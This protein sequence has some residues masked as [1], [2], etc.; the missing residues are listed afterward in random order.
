MT[1]RQRRMSRQAGLTLIEVLIT[2]SIIAVMASAV[3]L[4]GSAGRDRS[5]EAEAHRLALKLRAAADDALL[6]R[7]TYRFVWADDSYRFEAPDENGVY[8]P[9]SADPLGGVN[10][11]SAGMHLESDFP[12]N[13]ITIGPDGLGDDGRFLLAVGASGWVVEF[14]GLKASVSPK[15]R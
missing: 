7:R 5:A 1:D 8:Q 9:V 3:V 11:L 2:L 15:H 12:R 14:D 6:S 4:G 13:F 10:S